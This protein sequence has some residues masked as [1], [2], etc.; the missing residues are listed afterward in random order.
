M[1]KRF[2]SAIMAALMIGFASFA[3]T[4]AQ[5]LT[6]KELQK[7]AKIKSKVVRL[8]NEPKV[9]VI[10]E[11]E[12]GE[13][14]KGYV[15]SIAA[16]SFVVESSDGS[17]PS[18][19]FYLQVKDIRKKPSGGAIVGRVAAVAGASVGLIYLAGFLLSKC[20]VCIGP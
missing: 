19:I 6:M 10:V 12:D 3:P 5:T 20:S 1:R 11:L 16:D 9:K 17:G 13:T 15:S 14:I 18:D 4:S 8:G 7:T 2:L